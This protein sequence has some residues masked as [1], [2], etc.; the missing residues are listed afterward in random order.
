MTQPAYILALDQ[1][2]TSSRAMLF[3]RAGRVAAQ[4]QREFEQHYP[5]PGWVEH[6]PQDIWQSQLAVAH[7][8][9]KKA[10]VDATQIAAIG[11]ANQ[12]ETTLLWDRKTGEAVGPAIVWQDRRT[13]QHCAR[14]AE[15]GASE[16]IA[17]RTGLRIDPYF[18]A[19]KLA[20]LLDSAPDLRARAQRGELAFGTVDTWLVWHLSGNKRHVTDGSNASRTSLFDIRRGQWDDD[21]L[22]LF[23]IPRAVLPE[24]V[25][26]SGEIART[27]PSIFGASIPITG[28]AGDQQA[29]TFGQACF[30]RGIVKNTYGTGL[31]LLMNTGAQPV[32][33]THQLLTTLGWQI[34]D[35]RTY[36]LEGSVFMGGAIVQWLRDGLGIIERAADVGALAAQCKSSDGVVLAPAFAGLG[37]PHWDPHARG[38]RAYRPRGARSDRAANRRYARRDGSRRGHRVDRVARGRRGIAERSFDADSGRSARPPGCASADHGNHRA[39]RGVSRRTRRALL[40]EPR[41]S[42][43]TS[44]CRP[45]L[46]TGDVCG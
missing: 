43:A 20:W 32:A 38:T 39:R 4:A 33:S 9:L 11:I 27:D 19:T 26:S 12:R 1:G 28:I 31:F 22:A 44:R 13:A 34:G 45:P 41:P 17:H 6:D 5:Q 21:L 40:V 36:A 30:E 7:E 14:L 18:S 23:D 3:D 25:P 15:Q 10:Q 29:A 24:V 37:A 42:P 8:A 46:R 16:L 2:T 35:A